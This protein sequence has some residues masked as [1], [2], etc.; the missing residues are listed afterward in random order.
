MSREYNERRTAN[1]KIK[2]AEYR[3]EAV[4]RIVRQHGQG[5]SMF[6]VPQIRTR[7]EKSAM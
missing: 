5:Y 2:T 7:S 4:V 6:A 3:T 1:R